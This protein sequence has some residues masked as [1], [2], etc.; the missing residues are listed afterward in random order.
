MIPTKDK[1]L[2]NPYYSPWLG[3][4][5]FMSHYGS[6][7]LRTLVSP[8]RCYVVY[9]MLKQSVHVDGFVFECGVYKGGM[10]QIM[11]SVLKSYNS[12]KRLV[13]FDTFEG[14]P[15][16]DADKDDHKKGDFADTSANDVIKSVNY[17]RTTVEKGFIPDTFRPYDSEKIAFA[18]VDVDIYQS[19]LD[20]L[21]FIFPR[22]SVGGVIV[23]D[24]YGA[25]QC[26]G[27]RLAV[28]EYFS[29][30][31]TVPLVLSGCQAVIFKGFE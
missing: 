1:P 15:V 12:S 9:S 20:C 19:V 5:E 28:D 3:E 11:A 6:G 10:A 17:H 30:T 27:A 31:K 2:Y 16:S 21:K 13:L 18:H 7:K 24:D 22:L 14:L 29:S 8:D 26:Y 25:P 4:V 23:V